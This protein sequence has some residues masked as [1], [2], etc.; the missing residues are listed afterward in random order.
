MSDQREFDVV[1]CGGGLAGLTL[2]RHLKLD[3]PEL[4]VAVIDRLTRPLPEAAFKV[5][6]SSIELGTYYFGQVLKLDRYFRT[7]HLP[8]FG[9]RFFLGKSHEPLTQRPE[10]GQTMFPP[11]PSYQID[12]GRLET[13]LR[14]FVAEM[15]VILFEGC[16]VDDIE[17]AEGDTAH[18]IRCRRKDDSESF[19]LTGHWVVDALGRRRLLQTKLGLKREHEHRASAAWWRYTG[20]IDVDVMGTQDGS[21]FPHQL[22]EDRYFSTNHMMDRG[23]WVWFIPLGSGNT[24]VGIVTDD[25]IH[26]Q[27]TYGKSYEQALEWLQK[28]EPKVWEFVRNLP[29]MDFLSLKR[30]SYAS[31]QVFSHTRWSCVGEAG[32][33]LDPLYSYGSD[34]IAVTNTLTVEMIRRERAGSLT[35]KMVAD[36]NRLVLDNLYKI[37]LGFYEGMYKIFGHPQIFTPKLTWDTAIYWSWMYQLYV[38]G[39]LLNPTEDVFAL[40]E[41]FRQL[42][43]RVEKLLADWSEKAPPRPLYVLGDMTRMRLMMLLGL[44]LAS[45]R[46]P[47]Q[48]MKIARKNLDRL[49]E[50]ALVLFWQA[51]SECYP[52]HPM[53]KTKPWVNA[54]RMHLEPDQWEADGVFEPETASRPLQSMRDNFSGIFGPQSLRERILYN[55]PYQLL[56][57]GKGFVYYK[58]V[59]WIRRIIFVNKPA[60]WV[61]WALIKDYPS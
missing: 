9:L 44:D 49:E 26:P 48:M 6:E 12:R 30:Y 35:E 37:C 1:I 3:Q 50:F 24:S 56:H 25:D 33:F 40:G 54:W 51:V 38:Q 7:K 4:S 28:N 34:F 53:L 36:Y 29:P 19:T 42:N 8:K 5:G 27:N 2:A 46:G 17:L 13:D 47:E 55:L 31:A 61:R 20:R 15:G 45:R 57:L 10:A 22:I 52:D 18:I 32:F 59:T 60:M 39:M 11:V 41:R 14:E 58:I 21:K 16:S 23:Y 43:T